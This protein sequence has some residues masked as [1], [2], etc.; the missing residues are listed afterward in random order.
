MQLFPTRLLGIVADHGDFPIERIAVDRGG[1]G[2]WVGSVGHDEMLRMT[3]LREV[4]E[5]EDNSDA[6]GGEES[7]DDGNGIE[8]KEEQTSAALG[9]HT[10]AIVNG[11]DDSDSGLDS[12]SDSEADPAADAEVANEDSHSEVEANAGDSDD[13]SDRPA[14]SKKRRKGQSQPEDALG[15]EKKRRKKP[16]MDEVVAEPSFF[17]DL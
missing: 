17:A 8:D 4:L 13:D 16:K 15:T 1:E 3:D 10:D 2:N 6:E 12:N 5:A 7:D 9:K 14:P 11:I